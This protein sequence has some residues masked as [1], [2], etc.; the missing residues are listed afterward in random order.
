MKKLTRQQYLKTIP[1]L[2]DLMDS[3]TTPVGIAGKEK[4]KKQAKHDFWFFFSH[5]L[6]HYA[7]QKSPEFHREMIELLESEKTRIAIAAPRGFA[8]SVLVSFAY[9]VWCILFEKRYFVV[10]VSA[11]DALAR[12]LSDFIRLEFTDNHRI[13]E[14]FG[15]LLLGQGSEDDFTAN[16]TRVLARGRKQAV[17]GFRNRQHRPD[18]IILDD[19]E[20]DEESM[21]PKTI[22]KT[23]D[24]INRGLVPSL[25]SGGKI[26][27]IGTILRK[28]S[29]SGTLLLSEEEPWNMWERKIYRALE[30]DG[31][32]GEKSLWEERFSVE[33]LQEQQRKIGLSAFHAE[34]Q[35]MPS[36]EENSL[37]TESMIREGQ[38]EVGAPMALFIDPSVDGIK[39]NDYKAGVLVSKNQD[40]FIVVD[41]V[42]GQGSDH[43]FFENIINLY[44]K[45]QDSILIVAVES[46]GFQ[47]YFLKELQAFAEKEGV[48][49]PLHAIKNT[50]KKEHRITKLVPLF[51]TNKIVF[52]GELI[53]SKTGKLLIEQ[54]LYFP[55]SV[56]HDDGPDALEGAIRVLEARTNTKSS[57]ILLP[58]PEKR[59]FPH[60]M[61]QTPGFF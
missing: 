15:S 22:Q 9:V 16:K 39:A 4:R 47:A 59:T 32:G 29:V 36:D 14:D 35:N 50:L 57:F 5:Y 43:K 30:P 60:T 3:E 33:F 54:L 38:R 45:Y 61:F 58:R 56:V 55:D 20:K 31:N 18:L 52:D 10:L 6:P 51:E 40:E 37:F 25:K 27:F 26:V 21:S 11:T 44:Q 2:L 53:R 24:V 7:D 8:K 49:L 23:L 41:A 48:A 1:L 13:L 19:I 17:R 12:D 34:Y 42:M 28:R 46:N